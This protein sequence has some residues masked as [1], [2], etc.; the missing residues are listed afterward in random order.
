MAAAIRS[1]PRQMAA[2]QSIST[3]PRLL[4]RPAK[5]PIAITKQPDRKSTIDGIQGQN[6]ILY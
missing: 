6:T 5:P 1:T 4:E 3:Q 2:P